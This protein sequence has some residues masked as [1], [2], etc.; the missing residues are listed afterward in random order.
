[1]AKK[2][3]FKRADDTI[4]VG[5]QQISQHNITEELYDYLVKIAPSHADHFEVIDEET[6]ESVKAGK[7][8]SDPA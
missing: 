5:G 1:M 3:K 8:K 7:S 6:K 4:N 2:I